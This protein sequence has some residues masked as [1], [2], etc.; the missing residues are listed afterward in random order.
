MAKGKLKELMNLEC[1][2][3]CNAK[4]IMCPREKLTRKIGVMDF[5]LF[6]KIIDECAEY[7]VR[8]INLT[9]YGETLLDPNIIKKIKYIKSLRSKKFN[10]IVAMTSNAALI[11]K[12]MA[13][14]L[15]ESGLDSIWVSF[16][17]ITPENYKKIQN[18]DFNTTYNNLITLSKLKKELNSKTPKVSIYFLCMSENANEKENWLN[19]LKKYVDFITPEAKPHNYIYGRHYNEVKKTNFRLSCMKAQTTM[20]VLFNGDVTDCC[21]DFNGDYIFGNVKEQSLFSIIHGKKYREFERIHRMHQ[22][23]KLPLCNMCD[24]LVPITLIVLAKRLFYL[25]I[26]RPYQ[27]FKRYKLFDKL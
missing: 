14:D 27:R 26:K 7:G 11:N 20:Q 5:K 15:I 2:T 16:Y 8:E 13:R 21:Y 9:G 6:K 17:S 4:C 18:L 25:T 19:D 24:Q 3:V 22:F 12:K 23:H 10:P 1:T